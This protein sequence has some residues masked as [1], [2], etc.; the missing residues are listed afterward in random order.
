M[1]NFS[2][3]EYELREIIK[4]LIN[5]MR[6]PFGYLYCSFLLFFLRKLKSNLYITY[7]NRGTQ[8]GSGAQIQRNLAVHA[9]ADA[10][11]ISY[12]HSEIL[13]VSVHPFDPFQ[14]K[15]KRFEYIYKLNSF[16]SPKNKTGSEDSNFDSEIYEKRPSL[17]LLFKLKIVSMV[18]KKKILLRVVEVYS[19]IDKVP[20]YYKKLKC[21]YEFS[22]LFREYPLDSDIDI[23]VHFRQGVG[24]MVLYHQQS[25]PRELPIKYFVECLNEIEKK[26]GKSVNSKILILTD[27]PVS[28]SV[29]APPLEQLHN[30]VNTPGF[31]N[32]IMRIIGMD[33][34]DLF[35]KFGFEV[36]VKSGGDP[37]EAISFMMQ[38][39]YLIISRSSMSYLGA[40]LNDSDN[41]YYPKQFWHPKLP[42]WIEK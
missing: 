30:W 25:M 23:V 19:I 34:K 10:S 14:S 3:L 1:Q 12:L 41:I 27:A 29:Y 20:L 33:L 13:D 9:L 17:F 5:P 15:E 8:D 6:K 22:P 32:N 37:L 24:G 7:D 18:K 2:S 36:S 42:K 4:G 21:H 11:C 31:D 28:D 40:I 39:N 35:A 16:F 26:V 38:S